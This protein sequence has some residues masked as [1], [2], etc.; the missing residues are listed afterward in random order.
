MEPLDLDISEGELELPS[1]PMMLNMGPSHPAMHGTIRIVVELSGELITKADVQIGY[2]HRGFEKMCERGTWT[3]VFPYVDRCNYVSPMLNNVGFALAVEKM[4][5]VTV[6][7]RCQY[8]RVVLGEL[9]RICDHMICNGAM[10]MELGAFTPFLYHARARDIIWDI[11]EEETGARVTHSFGRVGGMAAPPTQYFKEM[12]RAGLPRV[13]KFLS[14]SER[15]LVK[16]RIFLDRLEGVG[17]ISKE[18]ALALGWTGPT[19]RSTG[20]AY[21]VRRA[22]PYLVYDRM[23]FD[24]PVGTTGD[25]YDR[26][27]CRMEEIRQSMRI[28]DQAL[29]QMPDEG[30]INIDDPRIMLPPKGEVYTTIEA[31]IQHFKIVMEGIKVPAGECYSYTEGGNGELGFYMVSD[32]S[33]TPYRLRIRPPCFAVTQGLEQMITGLMIPDVVPTFGSLN[34]IGGE[35]DH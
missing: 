29:E 34:M 26:F 22:H 9:A 18:D 13:Q 2:L 10:C 30:P 6:P 35:C 5:G 32:G 15:L 11:F 17:R 16:N 4:M 25:N 21:D 12:I 24:V 7:E 31:T 27:M 8:Y 23:E 28:I 33:G 20:A 1:E 3:Q 19:L 14:D